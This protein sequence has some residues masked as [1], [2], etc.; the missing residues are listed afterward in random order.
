MRAGLFDKALAS[1][2]FWPKTYRYDAPQAQAI[3]DSLASL[4]GCAGSESL[5]CLKTVDVQTIR[6]AALAISGAHTY[7]TS[8][9][10]WAPVIE[11]AGGFLAETLSQA[12]IQG[13]VNVDLGWGDV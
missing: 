8:S 3:Y 10:T 11:D 13:R 5:A 2:P 4:T 6:T 9:Y 12:T 1:S 7:N